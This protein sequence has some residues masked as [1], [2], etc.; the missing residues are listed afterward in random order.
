[1]TIP[2]GRSRL[3]CPLDIHVLGPSSWGPQGSPLVLLLGL[4]QKQGSSNQGQW[5]HLPRGHSQLADQALG[6]RSGQADTTTMKASGRGTCCLREKASSSDAGE[7]VQGGESRARQLL[8]PCISSPAFPCALFFPLFLP[9][10]PLLSSTFHPFPALVWLG[11]SCLDNFLLLLPGKEGTERGWAP[12][13]P[14]P[15]EGRLGCYF[16]ADGAYCSLPATNPESGLET[17][18]L[19][20]APEAPG[21]SEPGK[22]A[23][24]QAWGRKWALLGKSKLTAELP[25]NCSSFLFLSLI[26]WQEGWDGRLWLLG[27]RSLSQL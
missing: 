5:P 24:G 16:Q 18:R 25:P 1:M 26:C 10:F 3:T 12:G 23:G 13:W 4:D 22:P 21:T 2:Q 27:P 11:C 19:R 15:R 20:V 14:G 9:C 8:F 6:Q 7:W 17:R